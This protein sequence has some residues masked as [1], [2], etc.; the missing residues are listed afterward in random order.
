MKISMANKKNGPCIYIFKHITIN[1]KRTT[2]PLKSLVSL[3]TLC[4]KLDLST[5]EVLAWAKERALQMSKDN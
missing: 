5:E 4:K 2:K 3:N 1:G